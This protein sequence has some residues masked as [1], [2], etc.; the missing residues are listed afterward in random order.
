MVSEMQEQTTTSWDVEDDPLNALL[1]LESRRYFYG[2]HRPLDQAPHSM[3][4]KPISMGRHAPETF[5]F[6]FAE[7]TDR[8][9][10]LEQ[11]LANANAHFRRKAWEVVADDLAMSMLADLH[12]DLVVDIAALN[13]TDQSLALAKLAAA[14]F[15]E[16]GASVV[17]ITDAGHTSFQ[18]VEE[19]WNTLQSAAE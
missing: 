15:V 17:S 10:E 3:E 4:L 6:A 5:L 19:K 7:D 11:R 16:I 18:S 12:A 8:V 13:L 14:G 9:T 2:R 1:E